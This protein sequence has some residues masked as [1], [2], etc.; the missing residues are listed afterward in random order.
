MQQYE[1]K[2]WLAMQETE[3]KKRHPV[4]GV[5][6]VLVALVL[7]DFICG[8]LFL[9]RV[10]G[11]VSEQF[12]HDLKPN[13][14]S[15]ENFHGKKY[16]L[17]TDSL[18]FTD[19]AVR[20]VAPRTD[21]YR[22]MLLG[23]SFVESVGVDYQ[24]SF[25]G[26]FAREL[27]ERYEILNPSMGSYSP[28]LFYLKLKYLL[29]QKKLAVDEIYLFMDVSHAQDELFHEDFQPGQDLRAVRLRLFLRNNF[30]VLNRILINFDMVNHEEVNRKYGWTERSWR[31]ERPLWT[32][33]EEKYRRW[34]ARGLELA[35]QNAAKTVELC[36]AHKIRVNLVVYPLSAQIQA[37]DLDSLQ[38]RHWEG[39]CRQHGVRFVNLFPLFIDKSR[40]AEMTEN[41]LSSICIPG[42]YHWNEAGHKLV[43]EALV[44]DWRAAKSSG[45]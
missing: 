34:G 42:E 20:E 26:I 8:Q 15:V 3:V 4:L 31:E 33:D 37:N 32:L 27:G 36:A 24:N 44:R 45:K 19:Y 12:H 16:R 29:E 28:K 11:V 13:L 38:V 5:L 9:P 39:F 14:D 10:K 1:K 22:V 40:P 17:Y 6:A 18:G 41:F 30:F 2:G 35:D 25:P 43:G 23:S 7:V 21:K